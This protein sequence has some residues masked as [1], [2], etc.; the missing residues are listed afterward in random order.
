MQHFCVRRRPSIR[1]RLFAVAIFA[2]AMLSAA[3]PVSAA[4]PDHTI[5]IVVPF[6]PGGGTDV[7][8]RALA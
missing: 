4:Y 8:A 6:A 5:K 7:V 3:P 2:A 1:T